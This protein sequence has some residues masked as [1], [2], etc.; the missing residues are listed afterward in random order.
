MPTTYPAWSDLTVD[1]AGNL[2]VLASGPTGSGDHWVVFDPDGRM[3]G[4]V[5]AP[6]REAVRM[7][8]TRERVY[9]VVRDGGANGD[10]VRVYR[11]NH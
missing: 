3:L 7:F 1:G 4:N 9:A 10:E 2:W 8:W 11:I 6:F 5:P